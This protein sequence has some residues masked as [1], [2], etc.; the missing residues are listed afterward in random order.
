MRSHFLLSAVA[1]F[2]I[3]SANAADLASGK[4]APVAP[5]VVSPWDYTIGAGA[6]T[7][8]LFRGIS[9][10]DNKPSVNANAEIRYTFSDMFTGYVGAAASSIKLTNSDASPPVEL[11]AIAGVRATIGNFGVDVG[12]IAYVYPSFTTNGPLGVFPTNPT[13]WEGYVKTT[14][15]IND[16]ITVG[17][18][19]F[20][21]PSFLD[22]GASGQYLAA[23][24]A[25]KLPMDFALSGELGRQFLGTA[26]TKHGGANLPDYTYWNVGASYT[27]KVATLD[28]RYHDT[29]LS[30]T[31]CAAIT[32]PSNGVSGGASKYCNA[33]FVAT[34]SFAL[35]AK[36]IK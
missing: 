13:Y 31:Q 2:A 5:V 35:T 18:N 4:G 32:G 26:D 12:A 22:T 1:V 34:L 7:N 28:L 36:D 33:A 16:N 8:Y 29:N 6:T 27:Y 23:T 17:A 19:G 9:Q 15:A 3:T 11:D 24:L 20:F 14:Y 21:S 25:W 10:S 30:K